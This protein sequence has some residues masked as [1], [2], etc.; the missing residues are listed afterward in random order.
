[1]IEGGVLASL[2]TAAEWK[3]GRFGCDMFEGREIGS[4]YVSLIYVIS[5]AVTPKYVEPEDPSRSDQT[6]EE[7]NVES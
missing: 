3:G 7:Q 5:L 4:L 2:G 6:T 1:M